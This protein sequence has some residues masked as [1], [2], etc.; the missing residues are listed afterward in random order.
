MTQNVFQISSFAPIRKDAPVGRGERLRTVRDAQPLTQEEISDNRLE[1][2]PP[3]PN[4]DNVR[5]NYEQNPFPRNLPVRFLAYGFAVDR[6]YIEA[7]SGV[8][9]EEFMN[10]LKRA[11]VEVRRQEGDKRVIRHHMSQLVDWEKIGLEYAAFDDGT[12]S[13][14]TTAVN[15]R[16]KVLHRIPD[17]DKVSLKP[18]ERFELTIRFDAESDI[19]AE[20]DLELYL[21]GFL[22]I[23]HPPY[24]S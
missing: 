1:L 9:P 3:N 7:A 20:A 13:G 22:Q 21:Y 11:A 14:S 10:Q 4:R 17:P 6:P 19:P 8:T 24:R 23:S 5:R 16:T 12:D 15:F 18:D 2:F